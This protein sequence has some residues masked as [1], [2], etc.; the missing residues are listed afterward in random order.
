MLSYRPNVAALLV[1]QK[2]ELLIAERKKKKGAWQFPQGGVDKGE[3]P[4]EGLK[5]EVFEE[6]GLT[7]DCYKIKHSKS[8]YKYLYP[9]AVAKKKKYDGQKQMYYLCELKEG[10][11][12]IVI[13]KDNVEFRDAKWVK[14][15]DFEASWV[16]DFK[17]PV[18]RQVMLDFFGVS[19]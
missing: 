10:A 4:V 11:P 9:K 18:Y 3:S 7:S 6:I 13:T 15:E 14:P 5:R 17:L 2:G 19:I 16:P 12:E 8:G 1:N